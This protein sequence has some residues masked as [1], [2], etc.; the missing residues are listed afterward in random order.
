MI[1]WNLIFLGAIV[2]SWVLGVEGNI[3]FFLKRWKAPELERKK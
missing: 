1:L 3:I 2:V